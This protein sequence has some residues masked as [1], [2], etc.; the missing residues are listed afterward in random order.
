MD[1]YISRFHNTLWPWL[2]RLPKEEQLAHCHDAAAW[3]LKYEQKMT[4]KEQKEHNELEAWNALTE[5]EKAEIS[6]DITALTAHGLIVH[7]DA[8]AHKLQMEAMAKDKVVAKAKA[9]AVAQYNVV[10]R[11]RQKRLKQQQEIL[12]WANKVQSMTESQRML[13]AQ[14]VANAKQKAQEKAK[15]QHQL[16]VVKIRLKLQMKQTLKKFDAYQKHERAEF[17]KLQQIEFNKALASDKAF[18]T[19]MAKE[20]AMPSSRVQSES[21]SHLHVGKT[22]TGQPESFSPW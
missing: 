13:E 22:P 21:S 4:Q 19:A 15:K 8:K 1:E 12:A 10:E 6:F 2:H 18:N 9:K 7:K 16:K 14:K 3:A 11:Q 20:I 5:E 17:K